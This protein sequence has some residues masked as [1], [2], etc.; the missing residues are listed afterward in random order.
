[1]KK[2]LLALV[3]FT[4]LL[5]TTVIVVGADYSAPTPDLLTRG[6]LDIYVNGGASTLPDAALLGPD[7]SWPPSYGM[8]AGDD[9]FSCTSARKP[10]KTIA[11]ALTR[12]PRRVRHPVNVWV[13]PGT[14]AEGIVL[15]FETSGAGMVY[16]NG[17]L[18]TYGPDAGSSHFILGS[19]VGASNSWSYEATPCSADGGTWSGG[20]WLD[21]G[22]KGALARNTTGVK[23]QSFYGATLTTSTYPITEHSVPSDGG[24]IFVTLADGR[25]GLTSYAGNVYEVVRPAV[26]IAGAS[27]TAP[28]VEAYGNQSNVIFSNL[29]YTG[30]STQYGVVVGRQALN[31]VEV[32]CTGCSGARGI[33][34][35]HGGQL[36][37][38]WTIVR[39][40]V[41]QYTVMEQMASSQVYLHSALLLGEVSA[42]GGYLSSLGSGISYYYGTSS[43]LPTAVYSAGSIFDLTLREVPPPASHAGIAIMSMSRNLLYHSLVVGSTAEGVRVQGPTYFSAHTSDIVNSATYGIVAGST[44]TYRDI[45]M[46]VGLHSTV[47]ITG[48]GTN[49]LYIGPYTPDGGV[50]LSDLRT[51]YPGKVLY[52]PITGNRII[53]Q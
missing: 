29:A 40:A 32:T 38:N 51:N 11:A 10:C 43:T 21:R 34:G 30:A 17:L 5:C 3:G 39:R 35:V 49:D 24:A 46:Q 33:I 18:V 14:Y 44:N 27:A 48:S 20:A 37:L 42:Y 28:V 31:A 36:G 7:G 50:A 9:H 41:S 13:A 15:D 16:V 47:N 2:R 26:V 23:T 53:A 8:A 6:P 1:M 12:I 4:A 25:S 22:L 52:D 19:Q 45:N